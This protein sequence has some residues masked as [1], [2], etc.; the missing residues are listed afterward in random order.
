MLSRTCT[1]SVLKL[2]DGA[3]T[4]TVRT[5]L[6]ELFINTNGSGNPL[7]PSYAHTATFSSHYQGTTVD[8]SVVMAAGNFEANGKVGTAIQAT[9]VYARADQDQLGVNVGITAVADNGASSNVGA[10]CLLWYFRCW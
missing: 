2:G 3:L 9:G 5:Q 10:V 4:G 6:A 8:S 1:T 7:A